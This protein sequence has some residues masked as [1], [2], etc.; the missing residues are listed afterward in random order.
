MRK[1]TRR[2]RGDMLPFSSQERSAV[3]AGLN[4]L[5]KRA[6]YFLV[7]P[8]YVIPRLDTFYKDMISQE[9]WTQI[10]AA[11][12]ISIP[13]RYHTS[14]EDHVKF[15][16]GFLEVQSKRWLPN[17][18][19]LCIDQM[20]L[21]DIPSAIDDYLCAATE[22]RAEWINK[23][24]FFRMLNTSGNISRSTIAFCL[25]CLGP[26]MALGDINLPPLAEAVRPGSLPAHFTE[27]VRNMNAFVMQHVLLPVIDNENKSGYDGNQDDGVRALL[28]LTESEHPFTSSVWPL[29]E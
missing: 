23:L 18:G 25:P 5:F 1:S 13:D 28:S 9:V 7:A 12:A 26:L 3:G 14:A 21:H 10:E 17:R 8:K 24:E 27:Q 20:N 16:H 4:V 2:S 29:H 6:L 15:D 22:C 19:R 11:Q